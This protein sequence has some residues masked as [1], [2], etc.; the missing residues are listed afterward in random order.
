MKTKVVFMLVMLC[1]VM[2]ALVMTPS[3]VIASCS[4]DDCG[5]N[6][7]EAACEASCPPPPGSNYWQ[8]VLKCVREETKCGIACCALP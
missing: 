2:L 7:A 4:G 6:I 3:E 5:C 8:C 1:L